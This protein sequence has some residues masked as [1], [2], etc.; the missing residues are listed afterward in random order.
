[1]AI[2]ET[3]SIQA[4]RLAIDQINAM[5]GILGRK[6]KIIRKTAP[7]TGRPSPKIE[8]AAGERPRRGR[9]RLLDIGLAQGGAAGVREGQRPAVLPDLLR[10]PGTVE[11]RVLHGPGSDPADCLGAGLGSNTKKAKTFFLIGSDYIWPRTSNKIARKHIEN[12]CMRRWW[13]RSTTRWAHRVRSLINKIKLARPDCIFATVVGGSNV[14]FY[15]QLKAAGITPQKQFL[16]TLS[17]TED[18]VLGIGGEN[19]AGFYS[20]MKY[21]QSLDN[22]N[23]KKF[24]AAFKAKYGQK[25]VI[26]DVTQAAYLGPWLW[27][28]ACAGSFDVD[29]VVAHSAGIEVANAPQGYAKVDANHHLWSR[30]L[31]GQGQADGQFKVVAQSEQPIQPNPFPRATCNPS[32]AAARRVDDAAARGA[33][34]VRYRYFQHHADAGL[35][36][37]EPVQRAAAD[38][39]RAGRHLRPDG[40]DQ[41]GARR[42]HDDRRLHHLPVLVVSQNVWPRSCP[43]IS[44]SRSRGLRAGLRGGLAG[45]M[46]ADPPSVQAPARHAAGHLGPEPGMQQVFRSTFGPK[47]V[48]PTLPDWLMGSWEPTP[49]LDIPVNGLFVMGLT[50]LMTGGLLLA[51]YR[52]R[53]GLR[54]RATVRT[55]DGQR[56]GHQHAAHRPHD[57]CHRLRHRGRGGRGLHHHRLDRAHERLALHRRFVP[58]G[59]VRRRGEPARH[60]GIG[61]RHRADAVDQRVLPVGLDGARAHAAH[62]R[63]ILMLRP[64]GLFASKVRRLARVNAARHSLHRLEMDMEPIQPAAGAVSPRSR[65][66]AQPAGWRARSRGSTQRATRASCCSLLIVVVFRCARHVPPQP[67]GQV[68]DLC[69]RGDRPGRCWGYGGVLSLG[70]GVFFGLGGYAMAMFLKLEASDPAAPRSSPRRAFPTSWTGTSSPRCPRGGSRSHLPF[71]IS[72]C[73]SSHAALAFVIGF[74]MFKRRVGGVYFA[75]ITQAVALILTVLIIGQQGYTGGVNGITDL[76]DAARLGHPHRHAKL[77]LYFVN[78]ALLIGALLAV[79]LDPAQQA[80]HAAAGHARQGRPRALL[81]LRRGHVQGLRVLPGGD[82]RGIGGDV[83]A[84]GGLHVAVVRRH[85]AVDRDGDLRG[86][87]R[88]HVAGRRGVRRAAGQ[89]GKTWFSESFPNLWLF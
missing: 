30:S 89:L 3:G 51:L 43:C 29:K 50:L 88:A 14:A 35:C 17:V 60:R 15:K 70:Q 42:V 47:E 66:A 65:P 13:A 77:V 40:R 75:I 20:S 41:H 76:Q 36:R 68:P 34:D 52:S 78:A 87:G 9:V 10:R 12:I 67:G 38:G 80:R 57:L 44:S 79:P 27:K 81:G 53:W 64:Q 1:M 62:R 37:S 46:G 61:L 11:E 22:D 6:I 33:F 23:N 5:G 72:R 8:E 28:A 84:A 25:S 26:G 49:G 18:E 82:A 83:H 69:V 58:G 7:P 56:G 16:L 32:T 19:F 74:A 48:S 21:F 54:V 4:E 31:I 59:D 55:A 2:S 39:A 45:R 86:R 24:V 73:S 71:S 63:V 85:R